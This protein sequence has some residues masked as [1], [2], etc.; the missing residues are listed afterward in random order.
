MADLL[1]DARARYEEDVSSD[2]ENLDRAREDL[3]LYAGEQWPESVRRY[4]EQQGRPCLTFNYLPQI[5]RQVVNELRIKPPSI[6]VQPADDGADRETA[7]IYSGLIRNIESQS[8][9][10][11]AYRIAGEHSVIAGMGHFRVATQY[12]D[13]DAFDLDIRIRPVL[14]PF[15]VV[16]DQAA[17][18]QTRVDAHHC[19]VTDLISRREFEAR[20]PKQAPTNWEAWVAT[21]RAWNEGDLVRIAEYWYRVPETRTLWQLETGAVVCEDYLSDEM[22][23][24]LGPLVRRERTVETTRIE[25]CL[26]SG[27]AMLED[28]VE[29]PGKYIPIVPVIGEE[30]H[31]GERIVRRGLIRGARDAQWMLNVHRTASTEAIAMAPKAKWQGTARQFEGLEA[32][33]DSAHQNPSSRLPYNPDPMAP[34]PPVRATPEVA[35]QALL[36]EI[37]LAQQDIAATTGVY[38]ASVGKESNEKTG[39]AIIARQR[40]GDVGTFGFIDNVSIAVEHAG[41]IMIDLIPRIYDTERVVRALGEDG[42]EK[43]VRI[44]VVQPDGKR[45]FDLA[46]G[47]YDVVADVGPSYS[48]KREEARESMMAIS[49]AYPGIMQVAPDKI[50]EAMDWPQADEIAERLRKT[51]PPQLLEPREGDPPPQPPQPSPEQL[52]AQAEMIK[53]MAQ[54]QKAQ[55]ELELKRIE[56]GLEAQK[57]GQQGVKIGADIGL[58]LAKLMNG[59][60]AAVY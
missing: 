57:V 48:T 20:W 43:M 50:V 24:A 52:I 44:N 7:E 13:D 33:Y 34:G 23:V 18:E 16:W 55:A 4:R 3:E 2:R 42:A 21:W 60:P 56:L 38:P 6:K 19:F 15:S 12:A 25:Q 31:V 11:S 37:A 46:R 35:S 30:V 8:V 49:Q 14:S 9:A 58:D 45:I 51:V 29:W 54:A 22:K 59:A 53:A 17:R 39:R 40:E 36:S 10:S 32:F 5:V 28:P 41:R 27:G 1:N 26:L 47:K